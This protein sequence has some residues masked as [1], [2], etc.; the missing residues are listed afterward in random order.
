MNVIPQG[1]ALLFFGIDTALEQKGPER[2][3]ALKI[4]TKKRLFIAKH[5]DFLIVDLAAFILGFYVSLLLRRSLEMRFY[6]QDRL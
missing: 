4:L 2:E 1:G 3:N 5:Y 6:N